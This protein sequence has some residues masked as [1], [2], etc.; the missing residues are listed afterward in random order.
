MS[1]THATVTLSQSRSSDRSCSTSRHPRGA[2]AAV[3]AR[4]PFRPWRA[5]RPAHFGQAGFC[6]PV[7]AQDGAGS[8]APVLGWLERRWGGGS[9]RIPRKEKPRMSGAGH[10][11][12]KVLG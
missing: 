1:P 12:A 2:Q 4:R 8:L 11:R 6:R 9:V 5:R 3:S 10:M 7:N